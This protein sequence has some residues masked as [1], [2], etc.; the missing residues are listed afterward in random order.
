MSVLHYFKKMLPSAGE[1]EIGKV[2]TRE[3]NKRVHK[4]LERVEE[5]QDLQVG[6]EN[7]SHTQ[8]TAMKTEHG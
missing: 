5:G 8:C 2:A 3:V 1:T 7:E 4:V 6:G